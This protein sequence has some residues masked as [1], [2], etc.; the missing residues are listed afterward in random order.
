[1]NQYP[2]KTLIL[3]GVSLFFLVARPFSA[4]ATDTQERYGSAFS[5]L[6][7]YL[8]NTGQNVLPDAARVD[9]PLAPEYIGFS[10]DVTETLNNG[11][12]MRQ[13]GGHTIYV[14][15]LFLRGNYDAYTQTY[16]SVP[17]VSI[18]DA[19]ASLMAQ[20]LLSGQS[21]N[22]SFKGLNLYVEFKDKTVTLK[23]NSLASESAALQYGDL[24][25]S[26]AA[27]AARHCAMHLSA[28]YC[29]VPQHHWDG[30]AHHYGLVV[31]SNTPLYYTTGLPQDFVELYKTENGDLNFKPIAFSLPLRSAFVL[32]TTQ[33]FLWEFRPM[34]P[35]EVGEAMVNR[36]KQFPNTSIHLMSTVSPD[37]KN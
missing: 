7:L 28:K 26:W 17:A 5:D 24:L 27:N 33:K 10:D 22:F 37:L 19:T 12:V 15:A 16:K 1:M 29:F 11:A 3:C 9:V 25:S 31:S 18:H 8:S 21:N 23:N 13:I 34:T 30:A 4:F 36:E 2:V 20:V 32:S 35:D 6:N 14:K